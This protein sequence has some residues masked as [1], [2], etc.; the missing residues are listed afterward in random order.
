MAIQ[1]M[2]D[3]SRRP[4]LLCDFGPAQEGMG[5]KAHGWNPEITI[6]MIALHMIA[7][8][9]ASTKL[10]CRSTLSETFESVTRTA[11]R[12]LHTSQP[13]AVLATSGPYI[14]RVSE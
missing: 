9:I 13:L 11:E 2:I 4:Y 10:R 7:L 12:E 8:T 14:N 5:T 6:C 3:S 1:R